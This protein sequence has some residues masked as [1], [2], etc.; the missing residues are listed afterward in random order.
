MSESTVLA[1][2]QCGAKNRVPTS[3][4]NDS[5]NC[6]SCHQ[7][8]QVGEPSEL[9]NKSL[10]KFINNN[11]ALVVIDFWASWCQPCLMMAP[12]FFHAA[13]KL[14]TVRFGKVQTEQNE[15]AASQHQIRSLP[16]LVAFKNGHEIDRLSGLRSASDIINWAKSLG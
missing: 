7:S 1:C 2:P 5:P 3:K 12:N 4:I 10:S 11:E 6:G 16:T 14:P 9:T 8:L 13:K 15:Q